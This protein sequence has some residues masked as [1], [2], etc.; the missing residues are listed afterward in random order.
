MPKS[1]GVVD[2]SGFT[3]DLLTFRTC[4][5]QTLFFCDVTLLPTRNM[6]LHLLD[7]DI[8]AGMVCR[9]PFL[10]SLCLSSSGGAY[11]HKLVVRNSIEVT[12]QLEM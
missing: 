6:L 1:V 11:S 9:Q 10:P 2:I 7:D 5:F 4:G 8:A 3:E 12:R